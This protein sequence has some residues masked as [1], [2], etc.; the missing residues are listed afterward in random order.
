MIFPSFG[1]EGPGLGKIVEDLMRGTASSRRVW[2]TLAAA[3]VIALGGIAPARASSGDWDIQ[4]APPPHSPESS[5]RETAKMQA[6]RDWVAGR[7]GGAAAFARAHGP[8]PAGDVASPAMCPPNQPGCIP[9]PPPANASLKANQMTQIENYYCAPASVAEALDALGLAV[10]QPGLASRLKTTTDGTAWY[11]VYVDTSPSTGWPVEDVLN[12]RVGSNVYNSVPVS[13]TATTAQKA[14]FRTR[15]KSNIAAGWPL[16]G[17]AVEIPHGP[18]LQGHPDLPTT[19][20]HFFEIRG[21]QS[22]GATTLY[23]DSVHGAST[24]S[25]SGQVPAYSSR[26]TDTI[27]S[28][29]GGRGY[30][31]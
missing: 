8:L 17:N 1:A 28:I 26:A 23:E 27:A 29:V 19:I 15:L 5:A 20:Y 18:H 6:A 4:G 21:Y 9:G 10:S 7:P 30:V 13:S 22:S 12:Y 24:I 25:W 14:D 3:S 16:I 11:G 31:W 2:G